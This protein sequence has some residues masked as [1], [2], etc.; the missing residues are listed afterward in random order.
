M[1]DQNL[2][3]RIG[4]KLVGV[5][6]LAA[7]LV[8]IAMFATVR[9]A[10]DAPAPK[11]VV[12]GKAGV[13]GALLHRTGANKTWLPIRPSQAVRSEDL[14]VALPA[15]SVTSR[16]GAVQL[17]LLTD[18]SR[19]SPYPVL[20]SAVKLHA[21][22]DFDLDF[23][24]DRGRVDITNRKK[25]GPA[26][27]R[28]RFRD[29]KWD[30]TLEEP[31]ARVAFE[32]YG[33]WPRGAR[34]SKNPK[35]NEEPTA[36][37][38]MLVTSGEVHLKTGGQTFAFRAPPGPALFHWDSVAGADQGPQR[39]EELPLWARP[40]TN[41][42][43]LATHGKEAVQLLTALQKRIL[44]KAPITDLL[45]ESLTSDKPV[46][47]KLAV[48]G[49][50]ALDDLP[51]V[52]GALDSSKDEETRVTAIRA[53]RAWIGRGPGQDLRLYDALV[54][55]KGYSPSQAAVTLQLL[56]SFGDEDLARPATYEAL[57][58][59]LG[60]DK[61]PIRALAN[62]HLIRL[63]PAGKGIGFNPAGSAEERQAAIQKWKTIVPA[64]KLP[65]SEKPSEKTP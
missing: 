19:L 7:G 40:G 52:I 6:A 4:R 12:V 33:R 62:F 54:K 47:R 59:Y 49:L 11:R 35:P 58:D 57:I 10:D 5:L 9:G 39:L 56:H 3:H 18:L 20:E 21:D 32:L 64:G 15:G 29:Q 38:I 27:V 13:L 63:V 50:A 42:V 22:P 48:Y 2:M 43:A 53:L 26:K 34:F 36:D 45:N 16:D 37:L 24:L 51:A 14:I 28:V 60:N 25:E 30:V 46:A 17:R 44:E 1:S 31:R 8:P 23:T 55:E 61:L 65:P 41:L